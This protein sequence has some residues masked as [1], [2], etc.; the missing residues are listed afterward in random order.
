M[1]R[2]TE[3]DGRDDPEAEEDLLVQACAPT[4]IHRQPTQQ[5]EHPKGDQQKNDHL[6]ITSA[7]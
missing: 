4:P 5:N 1:E 3:S 6:S 7:M 2:W